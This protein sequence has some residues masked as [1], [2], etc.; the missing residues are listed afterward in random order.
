MK[1]ESAKFKEDAKD[2][3]DFYHRMDREKRIELLREH[4]ETALYLKKKSDILFNHIA[5][6]VSVTAE[7]TE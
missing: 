5:T 3:N 1:K 4:L 7:D 2:L 6:I